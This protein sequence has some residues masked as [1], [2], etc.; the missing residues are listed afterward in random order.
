MTVLIITD[1]SVRFFSLRYRD[2]FCG[3][4]HCKVN[5]TDLLF[6]YQNYLFKSQ[7]EIGTLQC[8]SVLFDYGLDTT[9]PGL[10]PDGAKCG[11]GKVWMLL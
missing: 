5:Q 10:S 6:K 3:R 2:V 7:A 1:Y 8:T 9:D 11:D 4:L